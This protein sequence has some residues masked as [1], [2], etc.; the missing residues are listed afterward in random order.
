MGRFHLFKRKP[1]DTTEDIF[2]QDT[3]FEHILKVFFD[4]KDKY[5][6]KVVAID[7]YPSKR[8][9]GYV[10]FDITFVLDGNVNYL[11]STE[12]SE[13]L[14]FFELVDDDGTFQTF[15]CTRN[16]FEKANNYAYV[17]QKIK[18]YVKHFMKENPSRN[19]DL[20]KTGA[21]MMFW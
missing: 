9:T 6:N 11:Q 14:E 8:I 21:K 1:C 5:P 7:I 10:A 13:M 3:I 4:F 15:G 20:S 17:D 19:F 2:E 12:T 16:T 18:A